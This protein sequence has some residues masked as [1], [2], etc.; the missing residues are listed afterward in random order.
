MV[1]GF[2]ICIGLFLTVSGGVVRAAEAS[3]S[4]RLGRVISDATLTDYRGAS[5]S[6]AEIKDQPVVVLAFLGTECPLAKLAVTKLNGLAK[7]FEPRGVAILG[8]NSNRQDS[9]ADLAVQVK[10]QEIGFRL[11]KDAGNKLADAVGAERTPEIVVLDQK[12]AIRYVGRIDDQNGIGFRRDTAKRRDLKIA[13]EELL[14]DK[15]V[16]VATTEVEGCFI[17]KVREPKQG[18]EITYSKHVAPILQNRCMNCHRPGQVAPF[19]MTGYDEVAGWAETIAEVVKDNRM[20]PWHA[21]P[22][23]GKFANARNLPDDEKR[24]ILDWV[25]AG[26]PEGDRSDLPP[27]K[28][29]TDG[30]QLPREPDLIVQMRDKPY[31]V[32]ASGTVRY[33]YFVVDP[34]LAEDKWVTAAEIQPGERSVVHHVLVFAKSDSDMRKFDGEGAFLAAYVPGFLPQQ[35]PA[36]MAKLVPAG[37]KLIFQIHYTPNG[38]ATKDTSRIGLLFADE[39]SVT[40]A[41][42]TSEARKSGGL[43]IPPNAD[44]SRHE[45]NS[46]KSPVDVQLLN[47]MPHMHVRGKSFRYELQS[48]DG[49]KETVLDVPR[50]DFNWQTSYRLAEPLQ[51]SAGSSMHVVAHYDNSQSNLN[52]PNPNATVRWGEQT[53]DEMLIGYFD[54]AVPRATFESTRKVTGNSRREAVAETIPPLIASRVIDSIKQ[55][56]KNKDG[57][58]TLDEVPDRL[59]VILK[60]LDLDGDEKLTIEEARKAIEKKR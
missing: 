24:V 9:L 25:K 14:A 21:S 55:L 52:N 48:A 54:I 11:L 15:P 59:R 5:V 13:I 51:V 17:G 41:V 8:I 2:V 47:L 40:H 19:A 42:M 58:L 23:H 35:Y 1:R 30:W 56:D 39:K 32:P 43:I 34:K 6:L 49:R 20:P 29:Y 18:A 28:S 50:Y 46:P 22:D 45:A 53:W 31:D 10:E 38:K 60:Q 7:E 27:P 12:R 4:E 33:Q 36:G 26:A 57:A 16:S 3:R 37:S 44:N